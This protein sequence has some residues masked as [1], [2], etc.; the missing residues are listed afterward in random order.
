MA[1]Q[2]TDINKA[3]VFKQLASK[4]FY[5]TGMEFG[6]DKHYANKLGVTNASYRIFQQVR[7]DP[8]KYMIQP[9]TLILVEDAVEQRKVQHTRNPIIIT[10]NLGRLDV[11]DIKA[12]VISGRGKAAKLLDAKMD[13]LGSSKKKLDKENIVSLAK[14]FGIF[15]DKAQIVQGEATEHIAVLSRNI[16]DDMSPEEAMKTLLKFREKSM[17]EK[18]D[19][20]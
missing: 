2:L 7:K 8:V 15:F 16:N 6:F 4:S 10:P 13:M 5:E 3:A 11:N 1:L 12:V 18:F 14:V 17:I 20:E 9:E 19:K